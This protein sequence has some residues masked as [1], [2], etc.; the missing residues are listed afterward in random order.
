LKE[1]SKI[2]IYIRLLE[3]L[4]IGTKLLLEGTGI[5]WLTLAS[6]DTLV[7]RES[8]NAV[9][10]NM[11]RLTHNSGI[12]LSLGDVIEVSD[13]GILGYA[14]LSSSTLEQVTRIYRQYR[15][16]M[17]GAMVTIDSACDTRPGYEFTVSSSARTEALYRFEIEEFFVE[18][19]ALVRMLTGMKP[20]MR[21]VSF[22]YAAPPHSAQYEKF[23]N[24]PVR[25][26]APANVF[27][28]K[29]PSLSTAIISGNPD[30]H[31]L[32]AR[33]CQ[34]ILQVE[35][36]GSQLR[37]RLR[38]LFLRNPGNLPALP[39]VAAQMGICERHLRRRLR[40]E[41]LSFQTLKDNFRLDLSLQLLV[42]GRMAPKEVAYLLG[43]STPSALSRAFKLWTGKTIRQFMQ[44]ITGRPTSE[45]TVTALKRTLGLPQA[46][47]SWRRGSRLPTD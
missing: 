12:A 31:K 18:G 4:G 42:V 21:E 35:H 45:H 14:M 6:P 34:E 10:M 16:T 2:G 27:S 38:E 7:S 11:M 9:I 1:V 17:F 8:Y 13:F 30:L 28:V 20:T 19:M 26:N 41:E 24:C 22:T 43:Y 5:D 29:S 47:L 37:M 39:D 36:K 32:C 25:F 46:E 23:F 15:S 3:R 33:H 44:A 40:E